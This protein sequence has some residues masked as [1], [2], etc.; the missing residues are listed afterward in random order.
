MRYALSSPPPQT[1]TLEYHV[2]SVITRR[3]AERVRESEE[4]A[5]DDVARRT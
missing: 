5:R 4:E 2:Q 3:T 1:Q